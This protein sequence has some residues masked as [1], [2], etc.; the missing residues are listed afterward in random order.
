MSQLG[1]TYIRKPN[2]P[3]PDDAFLQNILDNCPKAW[4]AVILD[5]GV[6]DTFYGET[7]TVKDLKLTLEEF[8][9]TTAIFYFCDSD[10]A[11]NID[12]DVPPWTVIVNDDDESLVCIIPEGNFPGFEKAGSSHPPI[13]HL[14][15]HL[16][17]ELYGVFDLVDKDLDKF[18]NA[19]QKDSFKSK[20]QMNAVGRGYITVIARNGQVLTIQQGDPPVE[21]EHGYITNAFG[22][23]KK[24][25][26][27]AEPE[28]PKGGMFSRKKSVSTV[29][30]QHV[31]HQPSNAVVAS[32]VADPPKTDT[33]V[34]APT[35]VVS[36]PKVPTKPAPKALTIADIQVTEVKVPDQLS[37]KLKRNW[38]KE[39]L[40]YIPATFEDVGRKY[41]MYTKPS[42][43]GTTRIVV[44]R[45][46]VN[47]LFGL[48][49]A[50]LPNLKEHNPPPVGTSD[51]DNKHIDSNKESISPLPILS[52]A[53]R[54]RAKAF[55]SDTRVLKVIG[56]NSA[57]I[58]NPENVQGTEG[59]VPLFYQQIGQKDMSDWDALPFIEIKKLGQAD[60]HLL[61]T[62][63]HTWRLRALRAE[64]KAGKVKKVTEKMQEQLKPV[65][66]ET[67]E[68]PEV[69]IE[70][71]PKR[72]MF[73][74]RKV[75]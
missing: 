73:S 65:Q 32:G 39:R 3:L 21:F 23:G 53:M 62:M 24:E 75:A 44:T 58:A 45:D 31:P 35:D 72:G 56:E 36:V 12:K 51:T 33:A 15:E 74:R 61:A 71:A 66:P 7:T 28:K 46:E 19:I 26:P 70:E 8:K 43:D 29:R 41:K 47:R 59:K 30:E 6:L 54:E 67:P 11:L 63:A 64:L 4:G 57:L 42:A 16:T 13:Y 1:T 2:A 55:I 60:I 40:G 69:K 20:V 18:M 37:R 10:A 14:G 5:K 9:D 48:S 25:E 17:N 50:S 22:F 49:A 27:K 52:G 68:E 34:K 38:F